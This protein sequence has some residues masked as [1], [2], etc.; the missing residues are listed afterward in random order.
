VN[1]GSLI[2]RRYAL[3]SATGLNS[4]V[5]RAM[6]QPA[7]DLG[8]KPRE[9]A[10]DLTFSPEGAMPGLTFDQ[11]LERGVRL[12]HERMRAE[13]WQWFSED[14]FRRAA[15]RFE[16]AARLEPEDL[17]S[18]IGELFCYLSLEAVRTAIAVQRSLQTRNV[19]PFGA[20]LNM[21]ER[22]SDPER[23]RELGVESG[24]WGQ[25]TGRS[26]DLLALHVLVQW[27]IGQHDEAV[28]TAASYARDFT[29]TGYAD[30]PEMARAARA[31][32][33]AQ[34]DQP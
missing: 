1:F 33:N 7:L 24:L 12:A 28:A 9:P 15:R 27:Y 34:D 32:M 4:P 29:N 25:R 26:A 18:R 14:E 5:Y 13:A 17:E 10:G 8:V 31:S 6:L 30:W 16:S 2:E 11:R 19:N 20:K 22:Y 3:I 23:A 21:S